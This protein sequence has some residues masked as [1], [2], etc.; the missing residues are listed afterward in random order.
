VDDAVPVQHG[1]RIE[2][3]RAGAQRVGRGHR[4]AG[5]PIGER[6]AADQFH[7]DVRPA[8]GLAQV[9]DLA[10]QRMHHPRRDAGLA[11]QPVGGAGIGAVGAQQLERDA[12]LEPLVDGLVDH[13][14]AA[15]AEAA[16]D[17]VVADALAG[18]IVS[19]RRLAI[20]VG[21]RGDAGA[22]GVVQRRRAEEGVALGVAGDERSHFGLERG[23]AGAGR[24]QVGVPVGAVARDRLVEHGLHVLPPLTGHAA[25][26]L[27]SRPRPPKHNSRAASHL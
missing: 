13:A 19:R 2:H 26:I 16:D 11:G 9:V 6:F 17:A 5:Q 24:R 10:D 21:H 1:Q 8:V 22:G 27:V 18:A 23:V 20:G 25:G 14:H 3:H 12:P 7:H 15:L 4:P